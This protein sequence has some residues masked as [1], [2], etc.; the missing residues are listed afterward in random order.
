MSQKG[1]GMTAVVADDGQLQGVFTDGDL[2]RALD[3][4]LDVHNYDDAQYHDD[5]LQ[6]GPPQT[7]WLPKPFVLWSR[8]K[9]PL[10]WSWTTTGAWS[11]P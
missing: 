8:L 9:L 1:L 7:S 10:C 3:D 6:D 5:E 11:A 2:R 4:N